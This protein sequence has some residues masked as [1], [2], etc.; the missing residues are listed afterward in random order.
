MSK[1][2][3]AQPTQ[4][5]TLTV[6][7]AV[8]ENGVI[9]DGN[10]I[11]WH[12]PEDLAHFRDTTTGHPVI[13]G[14]RTYESIAAR[15]GGPLPDRT[16]IVLST[17]G[18]DAPSEV[19]VAESLDEAVAEASDIAEEGE[20]FVIGGAAVYEQVLSRAD[21]MVLTEIPG[22]YDGDTTFPEWQSENWQV[23]DRTPLGSEL[24]VAVYERR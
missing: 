23:R 11:P 20:V 13:M 5:V 3:S 8:A 7:A 10:D 14:R 12:Y 6:I 9:G 1:D 22:E 21:R 18:V 15:L 24:S 2:I 17:T 19:I 4:D 16:N